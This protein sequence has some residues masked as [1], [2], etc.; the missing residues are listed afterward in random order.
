MLH[1]VVEF[2]N[3]F[4][5]VSVGN[6]EAALAEK[7]KAPVKFLLQ[8]PAE[9][10]QWVTAYRVDAA[11]YPE[12]NE[13]AEL[14][15][16]AE[17]LRDQHLATARQ[18]LGELHWFSPAVPLLLADFAIYSGEL[19]AAENTLL[20]GRQAFPADA[21][22]PAQLV[23]VTLYR[24]DPAAAR[25]RLAE[26]LTQQPD[27][28]ELRLVQ[29]ELAR[30]DG[31]ARTARDAYHAVL[32]QA[33][34]DARGW[35]G[36]GLVES[37]TGNYRLAREQLDTA[38]RLDP[39]ALHVRGERATLDTL[40]DHL[41][42]A[43]AGF[44][45]VLGMQPDNYV[46]LTGL[47]LLQLKQGNTDA[48]LHSLLKA[49]LL[50]PRYS[51]AVLHVAIAYYQ[52]GRSATALDTLARAAELDPQ[53]PM[54]H[55]LAALIYQDQW[56]AGQAVRAARLGMERLPYLKS[57]NQ[58]ANDLQG[59]ANL[60]A[61]F[62]QFGLEESA[63]L[64][65]QDSYDP[66]WAGSHFFLGRHYPG[67][68]SRN[69]E[70]TLGFL[71]DPTAFGIARRFQPL[72]ASPGASLRAQYWLERG[73]GS[74]IDVPLVAANGYHNNGDGPPFAWLAEFQQ[75]QWHQTGLAADA[76]QATIGLGMQPNEALRLFLFANRFN[77][78]VYQDRPDGNLSAAG[79]NRRIDLGASWRHG[80]NQQTWLKFGHTDED[81]R[82]NS[83]A[84]VGI[85]P[86]REGKELHPQRNDAQLR[87]SLRSEAG[88]L[89]SAG[90]EQ[91]KRSDDYN[92]TKTPNVPNNS[93]R[94]V[95]SAERTDD[96]STLIWAGWQSALLRLWQLD[97]QLTHTSIDSE[98]AR[99]TRLSFGRVH[100]GGE[101]G[102]ERWQLRLGGLIHPAP[103]WTL[104]AAW[105]DWTRPFS[106]NT[107][108]P[109]A[110]AGIPVDD[111]YTLPGG[112]L[113]RLKLQAEWQHK[114]GLTL[115]WADHRE[116]EN[117][118]Y[119]CVDG[120]IY[121]GSELAD[122]SRLDVRTL[123]NLT[124]DDPLGQ[125]VFV[126]GRLDETGIGHE[127]IL[128]DTLS[129]GIQLRQTQSKSTQCHLASALS[130]TPRQQAG[131]GATWL[132]APRWLIQARAIW[133]NSQ[134]A[135]VRHTDTSAIAAGWETTL[136][137]S[138]QAPRKDWQID[139]Y[140]KQEVGDGGTAAG[141]AVQWRY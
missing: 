115:A 126:G 56:E 102:E 59:S 13:S 39:G 87:H 43:Q 2:S 31:A 60:G 49:N 50:E 25:Q 125:P 83:P 103:G 107:L 77:P 84:Y 79:S 113:K 88:H 140:L 16:I 45:E 8:N 111:H 9:R 52:Q 117:L 37:E 1:G 21:R 17:L 101:T 109:V 54:P 98:M 104:R 7:G 96:R 91:A 138:W 62:A 136:R 95:T 119:D 32:A 20:K 18:R 38:L 106:F 123:Q 75:P 27:A 81:S 51:R 46:A 114:H 69:A 29:G 41:A 74:R 121:R 94:P 133:R 5:A 129:F 116:I 64:A 70:L 71:T 26:A 36:L 19:D 4:G 66:F 3:S 131:I 89:W 35:Q 132:P 42:A 40:V 97:A 134:F 128:S 48:A 72:V 47:G 86:G 130:Y 100:E 15:T 57:L 73:N 141:M 80:P 93:P 34:Q 11:R 23:R 53:D 139:T 33:P 30:F 122:L 58:L 137:G 110:T 10:V 65:A 28:I 108:A 67:E 24:N 90:L 61:A 22:F 85:L 12:I 76:G 124:L 127:Q 68:F 78:E 6:G 105:Q 82:I 99:D 14:R 135:D 112:R 120:A 44:D 92:A 63:R 55:F 118:A